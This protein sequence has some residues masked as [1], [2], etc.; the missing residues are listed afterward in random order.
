[1]I[2]RQIDRIGR[3]IDRQKDRKRDKTDRKR[4]IPGSGFSRVDTKRQKDDIQIDGIDRQIEEQRER[5]ID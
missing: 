5:Q 1:M 2:F 4:D 3:N